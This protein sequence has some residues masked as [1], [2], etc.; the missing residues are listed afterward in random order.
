MVALPKLLDGLIQPLA[1]QVVF[2]NQDYLR[3]LLLEQP[4]H[5]LPRPVNPP[6]GD[7]SLQRCDVH[8]Q[9]VTVTFFGFGLRGVL[10]PLIMSWQS[11]FVQISCGLPWP[12]PG[13]MGPLPGAVSGPPTL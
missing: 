10:G 2:L 5:L 12:R 7:E 6:L 4:V 3:L 13:G 11:L 8:L 9:N 1:P